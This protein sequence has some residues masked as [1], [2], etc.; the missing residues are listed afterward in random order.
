MNRKRS[1]SGKMILLLM[2]FFMAKG[3]HAQNYRATWE[4]LDKRPVPQWYKDAKFGIFIHWGVYSVPAF[5][6]KGS[7]AEWYQNRL[8]S[9]DSATV[10]Y[11]KKVFG[12]LTYYQIADRFKAE[13]F[14]PDEWAKVIEE[15]G[16]KYVVLTSKHHDGFA[17]WPSKEATDSWGFPWNAAVAGPH[18]DLLGDLF[19]ALRKTTV[20]AGLYYSLYEWYNPLW[21]TDRKKYVDEHEWPQ[22]KDVINTY[23]PDVF[24][25]DGEWDESADFW[26]SKEFLQW[27][28]NESPIKD[29]VVTYDR[30]GNGVRFKHGGVYT[31][32]YQP[33]VN[34]S[35]HYWEESRGMGFSYGYNREEDAWDYNSAK[36]LVLQLA[37]KV[38]GG[39]NFLLDIGP[40]GHGKIP[41]IMQERLLQI[42]NWMKYNHEA[43]Y[44]TVRWRTKAQWSEGNRNYNPATSSGDVLLKLTV[45]P[46]PGYAV[47]QCFFTYNPVENNLYAILPVWPKEKF[48]L[49]DLT[50][51]PGSK[52]TL[53]QTGETL[54][55]TQQ[56]KDVRVNFP[57]FDPAKIK[58]ESAYV[59]KIGS[60]GKFAG[61]PTID[62]SYP[63][64][65]LKPR[66]TITGQPGVEIH[67]TLDGTVPELSSPKYAKP[68]LAD[69]SGKLSVRSFKD[70]SLPGDTLSAEITVLNY[71]PAIKNTAS[72]QNGLQ[73]SAYELSPKSVDDLETAKP[74]KETIVRDISLDQLPREEYAGLM[75]KGYV[76]VPQ[77]GIYTFFLSADDGGKLW[78]D[79]QLVVD[80]DGT[81]SNVEKSGR[82][83]LGK[84]L[85]VFKL[86]YIQDKSTKFL[87][88]KYQADA[89]AKK[90]LPAAFYRTAK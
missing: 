72:L 8:K 28:Y 63:A 25:T 65:S 13:L 40:D 81:H 71:L 67:Y 51:T 79:Q 86:S 33:N 75:Y 57:P 37:D 53:L 4:S 78:I 6:P 58:D 10:A 89:G 77:Q 43:I 88:L 62:I 15:S 39:G 46:D 23:K 14:N 42:G 12:D 90:D 45:D 82:I 59:I 69:H 41:P 66:I 56:G 55:W 7:Y 22:M 76:Q 29:K 35:D 2:L 87:N 74:V 44:N 32:E 5:A 31:P 16:A 84:G 83:A 9:G 20:H 18:R 3:A 27:M 47:M 1:L 19:K 61:N 64:K 73:M 38:S 60:F 70:G 49:R 24:W 11:N 26:K 85:H 68:F 36:A 80:N 17:L 54:D 21:L 34:F 52:I 30:W 50:M 48:A